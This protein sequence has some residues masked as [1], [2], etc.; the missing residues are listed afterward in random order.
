MELAAQIVSLATVVKVLIDAAVAPIKK[1][2]PNWDSW[3]LF[4]VSLVLGAA[5]GWLSEMNL[6][7]DYFPNEYV[8]RTLTSLAIGVGPTILHEILSALGIKLAPRG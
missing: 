3:Y 4:Y 1:K 2:Y 6:F 8:G 7:V 5:V